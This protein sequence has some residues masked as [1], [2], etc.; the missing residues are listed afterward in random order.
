MFKICL[1]CFGSLES[2]LERFIIRY[3]KH[4]ELKRPPNRGRVKNMKVEGVSCCY[5][6]KHFPL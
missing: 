5:G 1:Y 4:E 3:N 2:G 6:A